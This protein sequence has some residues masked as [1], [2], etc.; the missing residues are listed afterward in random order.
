MH[1]GRLDAHD[2]RNQGPTPNTPPVPSL[3][4]QFGGDHP[5]PLGRG[6]VGPRGNAGGSSRKGGKG[7]RARSPELVSVMRGRSA[8]FI[9]ESLA[10][11]LGNQRRL[12]I[13]VAMLEGPASATSLRR[14]PIPD[15]SVDSMDYHLKELKAAGAITLLDSQR[16]RGATKHTYR[17]SESWKSV[18]GALASFNPPAS[19]NGLGSP[20]KQD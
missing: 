14:G 10:T 19:S 8:P 18:V 2:G 13:L 3:P 15:L 6:W 17:L 7:R 5:Q 9:P 4:S 20:V 11:A 16:V 12:R 1:L